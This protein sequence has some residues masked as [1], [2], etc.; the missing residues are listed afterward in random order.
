MNISNRCAGRLPMVA[1]RSIMYGFLSCALFC[2]C[3][4]AIVS[5]A[6]MPQPAVVYYGQAR[7]SFG[8]PYRAGADVVLRVGTN[9]IARH[10]IAGSLAP[11][12]NFALHVPID[13]GRSGTLYVRYAATTGAVATVVVVD[14]R[15]E[16][17]ILENAAMPPIGKPGDVMR[18]NVTAGQDEDGDGIPDEWEW[19]LVRWANDPAYATLQDVRPGDDYDGDGVSNLDEYRAGTFAFL[20]YDKFSAEAFRKAANGRVGI[21]VL[22]IPGK[23]YR[24]ESAP[25]GV[26]AGGYAWNAAACAL[27][28]T[29]EL[30]QSAAEGTGDWLTFFVSAPD[31]NLVWRL[32]VE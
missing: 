14:G 23:A 32:K 5:Q 18:I 16:R 20:D 9:E 4:G 24:I 27:T 11:G 17:T 25:I 26:V 28:E 3:G 29:G 30:R 10:S 19:E 7:D 12:V 31:S 13:D 1:R 8:W 15:G 6:G 21:D 2:A 22:T